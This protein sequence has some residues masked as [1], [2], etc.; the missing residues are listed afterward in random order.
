MFSLAL[1]GGT[2]HT[3]QGKEIPS[4]GIGIAGEK[5][6]A[7]GS[8]NDIRSG[9]RSS[10]KI[11]DVAGCEVVPGFC[12]SHTHPLWQGLQLKSLDLA[13]ATSLAA[14]L[15]AVEKAAL[16]A[17]PGRWILGFGWDETG[18][19]ERE[20]PGRESLDAASPSCPVYLGRVCGHVA[21]VNSL[22]LQAVE[23]EDLS[24][25]ERRNGKLT[26]R[27]SGSTLV[28]FF[29]KIPLSAELRREALEA[30]FRECDRHG[31][32]S[33][34]AFVE[35]LD[36]ALELSSMEDGPDV[37][38]FG[39]HRPE[40][41]FPWKEARGLLPREGRVRLAGIKLYADGSLGARTAFLSR[42]YE[43]RPETSGHQILSALEMKELLRSFHAQGAQV[44]VH[45]IGDGAVEALLKAASLAL[46]EGPESPRPIRGEHLEV[47]HPVQL[48]RLARMGLIAS[49]QPNFIARWGQPAG[50]YERRLGERFRRMNP[51]GA[52]LRQAV[53]VCFGS[54]GM[55]FGPLFGLASAGM[56][57]DE[58]QALSPKEALKCY[59]LG[60]ARAV[61]AADRGALCAGLRADLAVLAPGSLEDPLKGQVLATIRAGRL[62]WE[63]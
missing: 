37:W 50:L 30:F 62:V 25:L 22:A 18:W 20:P 17:D 36:E 57:P 34:H 43:D 19:P 2:I 40:K 6:E 23:L 39:I 4:G 10:T 42:P 35:S 52:F 12:D 31:V 33:I 60:G 51:L 11:I 53:T 21:A 15:E 47:I 27:L 5:I 63:A 46:A 3:V 24:G 9:C 41:P 44:A 28:E 8:E 32:T 49:L 29:S 38:V 61:G 1:L 14:L 59:T 55:P 16:Q 13:D 48:Y 58:E 54:D 7:V 56:H 26:G 45:A